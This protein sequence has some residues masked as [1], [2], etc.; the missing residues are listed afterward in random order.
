MPGSKCDGGKIRCVA[1]EQPCL[2]AVGGKAEK[3]GV[4]ID[5]SAL[6]KCASAFDGGN[7]PTKGC[8]GKLENKEQPKKPTAL[9]GKDSHNCWTRTGGRSSSG[10]RRLRHCMA[11]SS[12]RLVR[13][14]P[15]DAVRVFFTCTA[16][17]SEIGAAASLATPKTLVPRIALLR[18]VP[19]NGPNADTQ[20]QDRQ[21]KK[22]FAR[23]EWHRYY[24]SYF[25][26]VTQ[27]WIRH[28]R[29]YVIADA[30]TVHNQ[31]VG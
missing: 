29:R 25:I 5:A 15:G 11:G 23:R 31:L 3:K 30:R 12:R 8:V 22:Y 20:Q 21:Q 6:T 9:R 13:G 27:L 17:G 26:F 28:D 24:R 2:L 19:Q 1:K 10:A 18:P 4:P 16:I 7:D 14:I